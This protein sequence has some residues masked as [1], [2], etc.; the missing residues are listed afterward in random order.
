MLTPYL[1]TAEEFLGATYL[2]KRKDKMTLK[3]TTDDT[4]GKLAKDVYG[5]SN[6]MLVKTDFEFCSNY[7]LMSSFSQWK[8]VNIYQGI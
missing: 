1:A 2:K 3:P 6:E 5:W 4:D 8:F 7:L